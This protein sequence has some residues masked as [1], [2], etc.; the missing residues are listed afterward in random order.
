[1]NET[2]LESMWGVP[3]DEAGQPGDWVGVVGDVDGRTELARRPHQ[4]LDSVH[5]VEQL[6]SVSAIEFRR[7]PV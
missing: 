3:A 2:A 6:G 1:M 5:A 4:V 7:V